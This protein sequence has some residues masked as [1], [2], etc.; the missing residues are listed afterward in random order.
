MPGFFAMPFASTCNREGRVSPSLSAEG[1][2]RLTF[3][4]VAEPS[5][6]ALPMSFSRS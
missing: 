3:E 5:S 1:Q 4:D 2:N 6:G